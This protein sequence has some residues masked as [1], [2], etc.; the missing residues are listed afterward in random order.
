MDDMRRA[1]REL[2][3]PL[4]E[5]SGFAFAKGPRT[6]GV[7]ARGSDEY[8]LHVLPPYRPL[9]ILELGCQLHVSLVVT[10]IPK[11]L[12]HWGRARDVIELCQEPTRDRI[13]ALNDAITA[14]IWDG[15]KGFPDFEVCRTLLRPSGGPIGRRDELLRSGFHLFS[16]D[17]LVAWVPVFESIIL[18]AV[19]AVLD[20][21]RFPR[22]EEEHA[23]LERRLAGRTLQ[24]V[25]KE[26]KEL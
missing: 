10:P 17:D 26:L 15:L 5:R 19:T 18:E 22:D 14:R 20:L 21:S 23:L 7:L 12:Q 4:W 8:V 24:S 3:V 11:Y 6:R 16:R 25:L 9:G 13:A 1:Y 2:I